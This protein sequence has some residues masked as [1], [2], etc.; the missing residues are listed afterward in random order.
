[1][2]PGMSFQFFIQDYDFDIIHKKSIDNPSDFLSHHPLPHAPS[3]AS[4]RAEQYINFLTQHAITKAMTLDGK[5]SSA[6]KADDTLCTVIDLGEHNTWHT[7]AQ[8]AFGTHYPY[9]DMHEIQLFRTIQ[10]EL[11]VNTEYGI[12]LCDSRIFFHFIF[13]SFII[14]Q[15]YIQFYMIQYD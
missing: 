7:L 15:P 4:E 5:I 14:N 1:M 3:V 13:I 8:P 12:V 6:S 11:T 10:Q 9:M 2:L